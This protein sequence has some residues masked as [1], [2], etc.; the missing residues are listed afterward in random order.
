MSRRQSRG[1]PP[2]CN[3]SHESTTASALPGAN[4]EQTISHYRARDATVSLVYGG[5]RSRGEASS[6]GT[7][8]LRAMESLICAKRLVST[9]RSFWILV[10]SSSSRCT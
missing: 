8:T 10:F 6:A 4:V 7:C 9:V 2:G 3:N 5:Q 1:R